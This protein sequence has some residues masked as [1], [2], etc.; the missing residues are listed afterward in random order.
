LQTFHLLTGSTPFFAKGNPSKLIATMRAILEDEL[1]E[2]WLGDK[3]MK[4][5]NAD[6]HGYVTSIDTSLADALPE[7]DVAPAAAFIKACLRLDPKKRLTATEG[8]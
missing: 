1:P 8:F 5:Y 2:E 6:A 7:A 3:K 4:D